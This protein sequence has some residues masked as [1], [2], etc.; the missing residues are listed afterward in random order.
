MY[1]YSLYTASPN[2]NL[3]QN[4]SI[5]AMA[6]MQQFLNR[7]PQ[8]KFKDQALEAINV[9]QEKLEK[10]GFENARQYH[11]MRSYKAAIVSLENFKKNFPDS[12]YIED[13]Q[14]FIIV[15][16]FQLAEQSI[17]SKQEERYKAVVESYKELIDKYPN[18]GFL[19]DAER[20]YSESMQKLT[21]FKSTN[22]NI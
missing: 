14:Y 13:A 21:Q 19:R 22:N 3:D 5:Q 15:S 20:L 4:N 9:T 7:Y 10:K 16:Q 12:K 2:S 17:Y 8:S 6:A 18:S 11:K 1:A